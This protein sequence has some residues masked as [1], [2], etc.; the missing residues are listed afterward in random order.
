MTAWTTFKAVG[1]AALEALGGLAVTALSIK[2][3]LSGVDDA[4][5]NGLSLFNS[6]EIAGGVAGAAI[7]GALIG[8]IPGAVIAALA[9]ITIDLLEWR[10]Q[11]IEDLA[12]ESFFDGMGTSATIVSETVIDRMTA[13]ADSVLDSSETVL[14]YASA[15]DEAKAKTDELK[16]SLGEFIDKLLEQ[17]EAISNSQM[18]ELKSQFKDLKDSIHDTYES[19][20]NFYTSL[21]KNSAA[22]RSQSDEDTKA[23][24]ANY[25]QLA[26]LME[27]YEIEYY[28][29]QEKLLEQYKKGTLSLDEYNVAIQKLKLEFGYT[30]DVTLDADNAVSNF[31]ETLANVDWGDPETATAA[32][33]A[34]KESY[35]STLETLEEY[36]KSLQEEHEQT[37]ANYQERI[38]NMDAA[39]AKGYEYS[40]EDLE[41]YE[42]MKEYVANS[43][44]IIDEAISDVDSTI[45][46]VSEEYKGYILTALGDFTSSGVETTDELEEIVSTMKEDLSSLADID[47]SEDGEEA[48]QTFLSGLQDDGVW[49]E[50]VQFFAEQGSTTAQSYLDQINATID[51]E[52]EN[53]TGY[54]LSTATGR[55]ITNARA[56]IEGYA[57][58]IGEAIDEGT[59]NGIDGNAYYV[60]DAVGGLADDTIKYYKEPLLIRSPSRVFK[61]LGEYVVQGLIDGINE[62]SDEANNAIR[63]MAE[64]MSTIMESLSVKLNSKFSETFT[65]LEDIVDNSLTKVQKTLSSAKLSVDISD[66]VESSFN[67]ILTKLQSFCDKWRSAINSLASGM[68]STMNSISIDSNGKVT[69]TSMPKISVPKFANGGFP[70]DGLFMANH[71]ELVGQFSN[72]KTAV[73]NNQE[74]T[75]GIKEAVLEAMSTALQNTSNGNIAKIEVYTD[76]GVIVKKSIKGIKDYKATHGELPFEVI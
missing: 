68:K 11:V 43:A 38:A 10:E 56:D 73:A 49:Y 50:M 59:A 7:G 2:I 51:S 70:E 45:N 60:E 72:G 55:A 28:E 53:S 65:E 9:A 36:K 26:D 46:S 34:A 35:E 42:T 39:M 64:N 58:E 62:M 69:Y 6:L 20:N 37:V 48:I 29:Q 15:Y 23:Q 17:D 1:I 30:S 33:E 24:V 74:I 52:M 16:I 47:L 40:A 14:N 31:A 32:I 25:L 67:S 75:Q 27:G 44:T 66:D 21:I 54:A 4:Y 22:A 41:R 12:L 8:G 76:D 57:K 71:N 13:I 61:E 3:S 18:S 63:N 19:Q 5:E